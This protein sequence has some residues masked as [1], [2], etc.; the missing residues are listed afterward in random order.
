MEAAI[1]EV[2]SHQYGFRKALFRAEYLL[3]LSALMGELYVYAYIKMSDIYNEI[4]FVG[5]H[6]S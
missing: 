4:K 6:G 5:Y 1:Y 2:M 3:L